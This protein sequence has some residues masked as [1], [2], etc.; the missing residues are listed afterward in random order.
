[1]FNGK[2]NSRCSSRNFRAHDL[3]Y[4]LCFGFDVDGDGFICIKCSQINNRNM[5]KFRPCIDIRNGKVTQIVGSTLRDNV[6][7]ESHLHDDNNEDDDNAVK[8]NFISEKS[9]E[10]YAAL[11]A[12]DQ[13]TGG[14]LIQLDSAKCEDTT[15]AALRALQAYP[16]GLQ[17]CVWMWMWMCVWMC[18]CVDVCVCV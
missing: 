3:I 7:P 18:V 11:Y 2:E 10:S 17:V 4:H 13:L 5:T 15:H 6:C 16:A 14:H 9:A 1:M 12:R 8:T